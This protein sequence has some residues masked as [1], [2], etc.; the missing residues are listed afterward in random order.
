MTDVFD[1]E[2]RSQIMSLNR[3]HGNK[4]TEIE[5]QNLLNQNNISGWNAVPKN[6]IGKPDFAF[7]NEK[8][9]IFIDGCFWHGCTKCKNIPK[10][11]TEFWQNKIGKTVDRD[12]H[13]NKELRNNGWIVIRIWEHDLKNN[14][15]KERIIKSLNIRIKI[16]RFARSLKFIN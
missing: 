16:R 11:N 1:K 14:L 15:Q 5:F 7:I 6:I 12:K 10:T 13:N 8:I 2:K 3:G 4:S 9:A